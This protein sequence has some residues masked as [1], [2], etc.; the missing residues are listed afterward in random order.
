MADFTSKVES[1]V[2]R[3]RTAIASGNQVYIDTEVQEI[4]AM[5]LDNQAYRAI[6]DERLLAELLVMLTDRYG[7][8]SGHYLDGLREH[9]A[10]LQIIH[11]KF[12]TI[13]NASIDLDTLL[14]NHLN[15]WFSEPIEVSI[16]DAVKDKLH[17]ARINGDSEHRL[18]VFFNIYFS[19]LRDQNHGDFVDA[20]EPLSNWHM[21]A[22]S[23]YVPSRFMAYLQQVIVAMF[24]ESMSKHYHREM[25]TLV[26]YIQLGK[27]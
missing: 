15:R 9:L 22:T 1:Y 23:T 14:L 17:A 19:C 25:E 5:L 16:S 18:Q 11:D 20:I 21:K 27:R 8:E 26:L 7:P 6:G 4:E 2:H 10:K 24:T 13:L 3:L 12:Y